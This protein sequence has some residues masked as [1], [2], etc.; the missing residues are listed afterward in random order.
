[1]F[2][3]SIC[4]L[5]IL[6]QAVELRYL[7]LLRCRG[8]D[9]KC[10]ARGGEPTC[11]SRQVS[12]ALYIICKSRDALFYVLLQDCCGMHNFL[13]DRPSPRF[14]RSLRA[15]KVLLAAL[16]STLTVLAPRKEVRIGSR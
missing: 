11:R 13:S 15:V 1:M 12:I 6:E 14:Y 9:G 2:L 7:R 5:G 3:V 8:R 16:R 4:R 10:L